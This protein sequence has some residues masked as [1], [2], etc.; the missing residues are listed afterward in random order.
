[1]G[2]KNNQKTGLLLSCWILLA[3]LLVIF[4]FVKKDIIISN[5]KET[6]FF[7]RVGTETP[8]FIENYEVKED[9]SKSKGSLEIEVMPG[10]AEIGSITEVIP[11]EQNSE[12]DNTKEQ[13]QEIQVEKQPENLKE[14]EEIKV[15]Q[16]QN[17]SEKKS[18]A[19]TKVNLCFV[20]IDSDGTIVRKISNREIPKTDAPLTN[21]IKELIKG[22]SSSDKNCMTVIPS[23]TRLLGASVRNGI[24]TL[25]F[26][27]EFEFGGINADSYRAQLMQIVYTATEFSTVESVQFLIEGQRKD[28]MG[29]EDFQI[30]I[31]SPYKRSSFK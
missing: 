7:E 30:W 23:G 13:I 15:V 19:K 6:N 24:A 20:Y 2:G 18:T 26:S 17:E 12:E 5:L 29:S 21:T 4:F 10:P 16:N 28:Y 11:V 3:L 8:E 25:N 14:K 22:P 9:I 27:Q 1:M 31:G